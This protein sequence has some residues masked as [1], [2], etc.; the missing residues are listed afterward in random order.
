MSRDGSYLRTHT[1]SASY[2][3]RCVSRDSLSV[4]QDYGSS[5][6]L[7]LQVKYMKLLS[8]N[9]CGLIGKLLIPEFVDLCREYDIFS[10]CEMKCDVVDM[11]N[12]ETKMQAI[13]FDVI[14]KNISELGRFKSGGL[15]IA[16][17]NSVN[18]K[19][20]GIRTN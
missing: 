18:L 3:S 5:E 12:V 14:Y 15:I 17:E 11:Q 10:M 1:L 20:K 2:G 19:R 9:V 7:S 4:P 6:P 8:L 16:V 13:G